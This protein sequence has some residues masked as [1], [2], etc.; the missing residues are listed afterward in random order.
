[1]QAYT[2]K[3]AGSREL[4]GSSPILLLLGLFLLNL[5][6]RFPAFF[7]DLPPTTFCDEDLYVN[8][9]YDMLRKGST[10]VG[11]YLSGG[12][13]FYLPQGL[14][15]LYELVSGQTFSPD[16]F[17]IFA[18]ALTA[19]ILNS[20][21]VFWLYGILRILGASRA[22]MLLTLLIFT[23]SPMILGISRYHYPDHYMIFF[24]A[25]VLFGSLKIARGRAADPG[26]SKLFAWTGVAVGLM[27]SVKYSGFLLYL[28]MGF[29]ATLALGTELAAR[30]QRPFA[31]F[32]SYVKLVGIATL[33]TVIAFLLTNPTILKRWPDFQE[34][35]LIKHYLPAP[36]LWPGLIF[37]GEVLYLTFFG[38]LGLLAFLI[39][40][41]ALWRRDRL[42]T[43]L[44]L[45]IPLCLPLF[46][47]RYS[48][49]YNRNMILAAPFVIIVSGFGLG[50]LLSWLQE[51]LKNRLLLAFILLLFFAEPLY[52]SFHSYQSDFREDSR[53]MAKE[54]LEATF[55]AT[56]RVEQVSIESNSGCTYK[57]LLAVKNNPAG[58]VN[59]AVL[60]TWYGGLDSRG[61]MKGGQRTLAFML[62]EADY[63]AYHFMADL[64]NEVESVDLGP[65]WQLIKD[66]RG[67]G[68]KVFVFKNTS[69]PDA[70]STP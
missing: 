58:C 61:R 55:V 37:Y 66:F 47:A 42:C 67:A 18:R 26:A 3:Q 1:M 46:F 30:P 20:A 49:M 65:Q 19:G 34:G 22:T 13:N 39:G 7:H 24:I 69:C 54:W 14:A 70:T 31:V 29:G 15:K 35:L 32:A 25:A 57:K 63:E 51:R 33:T 68:P 6:L 48:T 40:V 64:A 16:A 9:G 2:P 36:S 12:I 4:E 59:Y 8:Y 27:C 17:R 53:A 10:K 62:G 50:A 11:H 23:F 45:C 41:G 60:D 5:A 56:K 43:L 44:L 38:V 21:T 28:L 52:R